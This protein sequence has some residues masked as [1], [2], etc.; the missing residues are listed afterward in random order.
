MFRHRHGF[1]E[2]TRAIILTMAILTILMSSF[3]QVKVQAGSEPILNVRREIEVGEHGLVKLK[4]SFKFDNT[5]GDNSLEQ[6]TIGFPTNFSHSLV[7]IDGI[8]N[9]GRE[10][11]IEPTNNETSTIKWLKVDFPEPI[12][13][14]SVYDFGIRMIHS[15]MIRYEPNVFILSYPIHPILQIKAESSNL[16]IIL[17]E[18]SEP[19]LA[20]NSTLSLVKIGNKVGLNEVL[21][22]LD[23]YLVQISSINYTSEKQKMLECKS[24][25]KRIIFKSNGEIFIVDNYTFH[26]LGGNIL[27]FGID[28]P[29]D[30]K[31]IM[32]YDFAG[33]LW[34]VSQ[35]G[36]YSVHVSTRYNRFGAGENF[37]FRLEYGID[38]KNH[39]KQ[40]DWWGRYRFSMNI[41]PSE[42]WIMENYKIV[43]ELP[44]GMVMEEIHPNG[45]VAADQL[46]SSHPFLEYDFK[47]VTPF[48]PELKISLDYKYQAFWAS[49]KPLEMLLMIEVIAA[50]LL[51][52]Y[53]MRRPLR[54]II[55]APV[56]I[57]RKF[58][59]L[60]DEKINLRLE[61]EKR[62]EEFMH[63]GISKHEYRRRKRFI[64]IRVSELN[65]ALSQVK[66]EIKRSQPRY[67]E[68]VRRIEKAESEIEALRLNKF[69]I[70]G[71]YRSGR[72]VK[73]AYD[74]LIPDIDKRI[75]KAKDTLDGLLITM[76]EE[77]R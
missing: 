2:L 42:D 9:K 44:T 70:R 27:S 24:I 1:T 10:L 58:V 5:N 77:A 54:P 41:K 23:P 57:I 64:E 3:Y 67:A 11:L 51:I 69:Q 25:E 7:Y 29:D 55:R 36:V 15:K 75:D 66:N 47:S 61:L 17:P 62:D 21:K 19:R 60:Q 63:G 43:F 74:S 48:S 8:D 33:P 65:R 30:A 31:D 73:E 52:T 22:P 14:G 56:E 28:I 40:L 45:N 34:P 18:G 16:T 12:S 68:M 6:M 26:N 46:G 35:Y 50:I 4:D 76:R 72:I 32:L 37:D 49:V 13:P 38:Q 20:S 39:I 59:D 71:Q 53:N